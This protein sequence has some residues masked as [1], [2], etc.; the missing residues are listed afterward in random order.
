MTAGAVWAATECFLDYCHKTE[1]TLKMALTTSV[2]RCSAYYARTRP[3][4]APLLTLYGGCLFQG[5]TSRV[6]AG[7]VKVISR[8]C[9]SQ[10]STR[11][12]CTKH[13]VHHVYP[14]RSSC[15]LRIPKTCSIF[16]YPIN[17]SPLFH[18]ARTL[19]PVK[20]NTFSTSSA[21]RAAKDGDSPVKKGED[22]LESTKGS[23]SI[24]QI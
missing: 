24:S 20:I 19:V 3:L 22:E 15:L 10:H 11:I 4:E 7:D 16:T 17:C 9:V 14:A 18:F 21:R 6:S 12:H 2:L 1:L 13:P 23:V 5:K 8:G